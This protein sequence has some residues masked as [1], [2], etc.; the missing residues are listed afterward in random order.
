MGFDSSYE[1]FEAFDAFDAF[2]SLETL[3]SLDGL[4]YLT[5]ICAVVISLPGLL[6]A[7]DWD[8]C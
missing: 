8:L 5:G 4:F 3:D 2:E 1:A 6:L 7:A